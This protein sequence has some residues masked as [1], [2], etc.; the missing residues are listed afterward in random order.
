MKK[1]FRGK[2]TEIAKNV[3]DFL[4]TLGCSESENSEAYQE[5]ILEVLD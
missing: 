1:V 3:Q 2:P 5:V 4:E